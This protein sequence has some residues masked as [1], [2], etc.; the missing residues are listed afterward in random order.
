M[1]KGHPL[2][3]ANGTVRVNRAVLYKKIGPGKHRCH[4][5][6]KVI[7]WCNKFA[8]MIV[9]D[10]LDENKWNNSPENLVAACQDCN[11]NR[12]KRDAEQNKTHCKNGH[13]FTPENTYAEPRPGGYRRC[14]ICR[15]AAGKQRRARRKK[16]A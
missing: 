1:H 2:A 11:F 6:P 15:R 7:T 8:T 5:C 12:P 3:Q 10:H 9:A 16:I 14:R 4:W 13:E